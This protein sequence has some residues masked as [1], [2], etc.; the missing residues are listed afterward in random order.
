[1][2]DY[3]WLISEIVNTVKNTKINLRDNM[4]HLMQIELRQNGKIFN[5]SE[6]LKGVIYS[7]L[8]N[9]RPWYLV[10]PHLKEIDSLLFNYDYKKILTHNANYY[11]DGILKLKCGNISLNKQMSYL[12][13]N[14]YKLLEIEY[15]FKTLDNFVTSAPPIEVAT[16]LSKSPKYK[17]KYMGLALALEY[18]RNVG[19]NEIKPDVHIKR[20]LSAKRLGICSKVEPT[21]QEALKAV[22]LLTRETNYSAAEIDSYLWLFCAKGYVEICGAKPKCFIC[23]VRQEC[24]YM[25]T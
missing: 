10:V 11:I 18:L 12:H 21:E 23:P 24:N 19:I 20:I 1:M 22:E 17:I 13:Q 15:E 14:I 8:T 16:K 25:I 3:Q 9:Q 5:F 2:K 4:N 6:H 7:L